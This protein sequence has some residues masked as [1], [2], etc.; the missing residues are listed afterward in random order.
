MTTTFLIALII[1]GVVA[2]IIL[3]S[4]F[5]RHM[6]IGT[7]LTVGMIST[8]L[9]GLMLSDG[10]ITVREVFSSAWQGT[11][12]AVQSIR[13]AQEDATKEEKTEK[14]PN[15]ESGKTSESSSESTNVVDEA[16]KAGVN[17]AVKAGRDKF[18]EEV[19][20]TLDEKPNK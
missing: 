15:K 14:E 11:K 12:R 6:I 18:L 9:L 1:I 20:K 4:K 7:L 10:T 16:L 2:G 5:I 8:L 19:R 17:E 3:S 13:T